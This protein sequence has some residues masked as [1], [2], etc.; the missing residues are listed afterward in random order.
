MT[1]MLTWK[2]PN[3][4]KT[5]AVHK[6]QNTLWERSTTMRGTQRQRPLVLFFAT[7]GGYN[8]GNYL[9]HTLSFTLSLYTRAI[10][11]TFTKY[12]QHNENVCPKSYL[13]IYDFRV[14]YISVLPNRSDGSEPGLLPSGSPKLPSGGTCFPT[15]SPFT[16]AWDVM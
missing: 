4:G 6:L 2:N 14:I 13:Y 3:V 1:H 15:N 8:G 11:L 12:Q 9:T 7:R 16:P 10:Q 5:T